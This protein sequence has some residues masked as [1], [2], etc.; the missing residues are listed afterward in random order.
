M[1]NPEHQLARSVAAIREHAPLSPIVGVILGSGLGG[2]AN[3]LEKPVRIETNAI[4]FYPKSTVQG[5]RGHLVFGTIGS[6]GVMLFQGRI[7]FYESGGF[8]PVLY[9]VRIAH[10]LGIKFLVVTNAAGAVSRNLSTGDLMAIMDQTNLTFG[11]CRL[12]PADPRPLYDAALID[13]LT[14]VATSLGISLRRGVYVGVKGPSYETAAEVEMIHRIGGDAVGMSTV[15]ETAL[16]ST[17][18][19]R[20]AGISL[21]TNLGT[22]ITS[23]R[24]DHREVTEVGRQAGQRFHSLLHAFLRS[25]PPDES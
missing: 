11:Q 4:P 18:G 14:R 8:D 20:V 2:F 23:S 7:H 16:A 12:P 22:G 6:T 24:L 13:L 9:P 3:S 1:N 25:L 19:M 5:H 21:I 10:L 17:L 15:V